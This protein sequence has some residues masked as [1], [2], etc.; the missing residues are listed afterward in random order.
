MRRLE[1]SVDL[2]SVFG[3]FKLIPSQ[4]LLLR[5]DRPVKLGGRALDILNLLLMRA[6]EEVSADELI[7][8]AWPGIFVD[9]R[10]LKVHVSSLRRALEDTL[11]DATYIATVVG[12]GYQ[13]VGRVRTERVEIVDIPA[14]GPEAAGSFPSPSLLVGRRGEIEGI[15]R[16]L[17]TAMLVTLVGPGGVGK[18]SLAVAVAHARRDAFPDGIHFVDLSTTGDPVLVPHLLATALGVRGHG[19][20]LISAV[21]EHLRGKRLLIVLDNCEHVRAAAAALTA[22]LVDA[23]LEILLLATSREPLGVSGEHLQQVEPL[24]FPGGVQVQ[25]ASDARAYALGRT[26][27]PARHRRGGLPAR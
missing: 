7:D 12:R 9:K 3:P 10:N 27:R 23:K 4:G 20:D 2:V 1:P 21:A 24:A 13:F 11:P 26:L 5:I 17:D 15:A 18:T 25:N 14:A 19:A 8:F 16:A 6:G 22:R